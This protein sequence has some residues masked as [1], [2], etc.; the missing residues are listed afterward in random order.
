MNHITKSATNKNSHRQ[1]FATL[2][3]FNKLLN[4]DSFTTDDHCLTE[5]ER[6]Y[7]VDLQIS[8]FRCLGNRIQVTCS[9]EKGDIREL[10]YL[11]RYAEEMITWVDGRQ[12][13]GRTL[14]PSLADS[15]IWFGDHRQLRDLTRALGVSDVIIRK[16]SNDRLKSHN[17]VHVY[18]NYRGDHYDLKEH[19]IGYYTWILIV[20]ETTHKPT[21]RLDYVHYTPDH[22]D[23]E[24]L[25]SRYFMSAYDIQNH[26][27]PY[28]HRE[29][30]KHQKTAIEINNS[31]LEKMKVNIAKD[32]AL[33]LENHTKLQ[34]IA[35]SFNEEVSNV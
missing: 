34:A 31:K 16:S 14:E 25:F 10:E 19:G 24:V 21:I 6:Q 1:V 22:F 3:R 35:E 7:K 26:L 2:K 18:C 28:R 11:L 12:S 15:L 29:D 30:Y 33:V 20:D 4:A 17:T 8:P 32:K 13:H 27:Y 9:S 5:D 23:G